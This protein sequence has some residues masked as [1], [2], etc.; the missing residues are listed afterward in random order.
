[1]ASLFSVNWERIFVPDTPILEIFVRGSLVYLAIF[2]LLRIVLKRQQSGVMSVTDLLLIVLIADAAQ[3]AMADDY[4]SIPDGVLLVGTIMGWSY[5]LDWLA[6]RFPYFRQI[7]HPP[8]VLLVKEGRLLRR[9]MRQEL[10]TEEELMSQLRE[11]GVQDLV[12]VKAAY[13]EGDGRISVVT[14]NSDQSGVPE[15]PI[16]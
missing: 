3:N 1:M 7:L 16:G 4:S 13:V 15:R 11:R 10:V 8:P 6:Y 14:D 9:N 12:Q 5:T 2:I